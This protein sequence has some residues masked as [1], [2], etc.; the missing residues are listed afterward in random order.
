MREI[1]ALSSYQDSL[2][3]VGKVLVDGGN[4]GQPFA[5]SV[6][7]LIGADVQV[8]K[9]SELNKFSAE[10]LDDPFPDWKNCEYSWQ[11]SLAMTDLAL[12]ASILRKS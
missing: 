1:F 12:I 8:A 9:R 7:E 3:A 2:T 11:S 5:Q 10:W 4:T 6:K